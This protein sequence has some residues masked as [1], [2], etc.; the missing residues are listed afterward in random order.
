MILIFQ[1]DLL[2][3]I[4]K[5]VIPAQFLSRM[6]SISYIWL[7]LIWLIFFRFPIMMMMQLFFMNTT[8]HLIINSF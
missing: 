5:E 2:L 3:F 7:L 6:M 1:A 8:I 4:Q